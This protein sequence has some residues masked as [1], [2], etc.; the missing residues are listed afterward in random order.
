MAKW[1]FDGRQG[2]VLRAA[3]LTEHLSALS[4]PVV[5]RGP[6]WGFEGWRRRNS[7]SPCLKTPPAVP[8]NPTS[9][10]LETPLHPASKPH[11]RRASKT[12]GTKSGS[13]SFKFRWFLGPSEQNELYH[14]PLQSKKKKLSDR[15]FLLEDPFRVK[16]M[17][18]YEIMCISRT[19]LLS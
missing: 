16:K 12:L 1:G 4:F 18:R 11:L 6:I 13:K 17:K 15:I 14:I 5:P 9:P 10:C 3:T 2:G 7:T 19:H 8:R